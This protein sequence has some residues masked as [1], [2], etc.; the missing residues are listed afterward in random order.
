[1]DY[2]KLYDYC[3]YGWA[4]D[5]KELI[6]RAGSDFDLFYDDYKLFKKATML[7]SSSVLN[8]LIEYYKTRVLKEID[9]KSDEYLHKQTALVEALQS[10]YDSACDFST[11][12]MEVLKLY[13]VLD[14]DRDS[15][16][17]FDDLP[18]PVFEYREGSTEYLGES[19]YGGD[20]DGFE[21][22]SHNLVTTS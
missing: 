15:V 2:R 11:E 13:V 9:D 6:S 18:D 5:V 17:G 10:A 21:F 16:A 7:E 8:V 22:N 1:M 20:K 12:V 19:M 14:D 3:T 4:D